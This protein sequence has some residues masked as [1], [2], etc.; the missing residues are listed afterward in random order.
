MLSHGQ[1]ILGHMTKLSASKMRALNCAVSPWKNAVDK[2]AHEAYYV[3]VGKERISDTQQNSGTPWK[4]PASKGFLVISRYVRLTKPQAALPSSL[5]PPFADIVGNYTR[6]DGD[7]KGEKIKHTA[8]LL[9]LRRC[10]SVVIL[11][12]FRYNVNQMAR[13]TLTN[14]L[15][16]NNICGCYAFLSGAVAHVSDKQ[17]YFAVVPE[18]NEQ[19]GD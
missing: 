2:A 19:N 1:G 4:V 17:P 10:G 16:S 18:G 13:A 6:R 11:Q 3:S 8:H 14:V 12:F 15:L 5:V 9:P 7:D